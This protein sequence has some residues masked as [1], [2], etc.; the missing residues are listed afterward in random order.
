MRRNTVAKVET[1]EMLNRTEAAEDITEFNFTIDSDR[2]LS[3]YLSAQIRT[4][5]GSRNLRDSV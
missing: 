4:L 2:I 5:L 3:V 1:S